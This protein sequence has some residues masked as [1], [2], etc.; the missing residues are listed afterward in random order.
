MSMHV[1]VT[2]TGRQLA[3]LMALIAGKN[4]PEIA[5]E[6]GVTHQTIQ[7][8]ISRIRRKLGVRNEIELGAWAERHGL[9]PKRAA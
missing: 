8:H 2:L 3:V 4:Q 6:Q 7:E 5:R 9:M 1:E